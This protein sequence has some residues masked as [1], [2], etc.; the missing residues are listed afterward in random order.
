[1]VPGNLQTGTIVTNRIYHFVNS[2][3]MADNIIKIC[4]SLHIIFMLTLT[5]I[6]LHYFTINM[7]R[8]EDQNMVIPILVNSGMLQ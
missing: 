2:A 7:K 8:E 5:Y 6:Y 1:M 4:H 3:L